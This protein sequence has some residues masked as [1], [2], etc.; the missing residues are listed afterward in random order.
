MKKPVIG[1]LGSGNMAFCL[2]QGLK[3]AGY[4]IKEIHSTNVKEG[5]ILA[6]RL[7]SK[8]FSQIEYLEGKADLYFFCLP[9]DA[10]E[11]VTK[12]FPFKNITNIECS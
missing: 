5:K 1:I 4:L 12:Q 3:E 8:Y 9:D 6:K 10:I 11:I 2:G 7:S